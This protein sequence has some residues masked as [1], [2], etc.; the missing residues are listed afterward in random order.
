MYIKE[1]LKQIVVAGDPDSTLILV[2][3]FSSW[4]GMA[5][6]G[7]STYTSLI[8]VRKEM[9]RAMPAR[10]VSIVGGIGFWGMSLWLG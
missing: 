8:G 4:L 5:F 3:A 7:A 1:L 2:L 9:L 6:T 10:F